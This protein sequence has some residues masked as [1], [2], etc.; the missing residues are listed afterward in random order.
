M[1]LIL[2]DL[3]AI[4]MQRF[5]FPALHNLLQFW[6]GAIEEAVHLMNAGFPP[7]LY[8]TVPIARGFGY[9]MNL[10]VGLILLFGSRS[11]MT[12]LRRTPLNTLSPFDKAMLLFHTAVGYVVFV[13]AL[14]HGFFHLAGGLTVPLWGSGFGGWNFCIITGFV[15]FAICCVMVLTV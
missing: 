15:I 11:L 4:R 14:L 12:A 3:Q 1:W 5:Q 13:A 2:E 8:Y 10:N 9:T 6:W 7:K